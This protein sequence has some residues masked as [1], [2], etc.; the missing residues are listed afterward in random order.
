MIRQ[1][2]GFYDERIC[3][4]PNDRAAFGPEEQQRLFHGLA[5]GNDRTGADGIGPVFRPY[6]TVRTEST[7]IRTK[8]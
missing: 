3:C 5:C 7:L 4:I 1:S 6:G 2:A 8:P